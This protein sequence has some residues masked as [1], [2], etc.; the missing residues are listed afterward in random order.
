MFRPDD[1][2]ISVMGITGVGKST[3]I[4]YFSDVPVPI[5]D[6]LEACE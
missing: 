6:K 5:G 1:I 3:F 2:V 4:N